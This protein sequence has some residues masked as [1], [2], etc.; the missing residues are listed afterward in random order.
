MQSV[1]NV[2]KSHH[3][4][5]IWLAGQVGRTREKKR[6]GKT[7]LLNDQQKQRKQLLRNDTEKGNTNLY[8]IHD[9]LLQV[10]HRSIPIWILLDLLLN[11]LHSEMVEQGLKDTK[12]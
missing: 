7:F 2:T 5:E 6:C 3:S 4:E 12:L 11:D 9:N 1:I 8:E 10:H